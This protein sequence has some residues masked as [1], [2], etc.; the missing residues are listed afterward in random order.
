MQRAQRRSQTSHDLVNKN[1]A[2]AVLICFWTSLVM[3]SLSTS[4]EVTQI[5][6]CSVPNQGTFDDPKGWRRS[7]RLVRKQ[8]GWLQTCWARNINDLHKL[9][10]F[11]SMNSCSSLSL[12]DSDSCNFCSMGQQRVRQRLRCKPGVHKGSSKPITVSYFNPLFQTTRF[13]NPSFT[14]RDGHILLSGQ[15]V[16]RGRIPF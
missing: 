11:I 12:F 3:S 9:D 6:S 13:N 2:L 14:H 4:E 8:A 15:Y 7:M 10:V 1:L 16:S 5:I